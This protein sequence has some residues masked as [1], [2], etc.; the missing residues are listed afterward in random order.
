M[1]WHPNKTLMGVYASIKLTGCSNSTISRLHIHIWCDKPGWCREG[2]KL[3]IR[4]VG[5]TF[6]KPIIIYGS[7]LTC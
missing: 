4:S 1:L 3:A 5:H 6:Q 2:L 7:R